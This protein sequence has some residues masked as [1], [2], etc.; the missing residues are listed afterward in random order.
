M[1]AHNDSSSP[2]SNHP[3]HVPDAVSEIAHRFVADPENP[4]WLMSMLWGHEVTMA[5]PGRPQDQMRYRMIPLCLGV[6][7]E[8]YDYYFVVLQSEA[9]NWSAHLART[10]EN[11]V[12]QARLRSA[13]RSGKR[14]SKKIR[15]TFP[16]HWDHPD[17][18]IEVCLVLST[19]LGP[20]LPPASRVLAALVNFDTRGLL[21]QVAAVSPRL[22][23]TVAEYSEA[24]SGYRPMADSLL[25]GIEVFENQGMFWNCM[26]ASAPT[27][28]LCEA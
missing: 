10:H 19:D 17:V 7:P 20:H 22:T 2:Q 14:R 16:A 3:I 5:H 9:G 28:N 21:A 13:R 27:P 15:A 8:E 4:E 18:N 6:G 12:Y 25:Q 23:A 1:S 11:D 26:I 24:L